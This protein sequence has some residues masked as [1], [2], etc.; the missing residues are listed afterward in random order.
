MGRRTCSG[1]AATASRLGAAVVQL[2]MSVHPHQHDRESMASALGA[3][4]EPPD[5]PAAAV[6][7]AGRC[8]VVA[9]G[10]YHAGLFALAQGVPAVCFSRSPYYDG[11]SSAC[12]RCLAPGARSSARRSRTSRAGVAELVERAYEA[13]PSWLGR[14]RAAAQRQ[15]EASRAAYAR[16][17]GLVGP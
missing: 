15:E 11:S 17:P 4:P 8:R 12:A 10:S 14:L 7:R 6:E 3:A 5:S 13:G 16:L 9:T 1:S 2:P